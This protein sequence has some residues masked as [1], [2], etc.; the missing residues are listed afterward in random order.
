VSGLKNGESDRQLTER[1][2]TSGFRFTSQR[3]QVYDVLRQKLDHPTAEG[4]F[5]RAKRVLPGISHAT[6]YN[7]LDALVQCGL[8][9]LV[10]LDR[11]A[12]R[13]CPNMEEHCHYYCAKCGTVFDVALPADSPTMPRP[14]GFKIDH[15]EIA[16]HGLCADCAAK[17]KK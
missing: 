2:A 12:T 11:G 14:K 9:R 13:Y 3:R 4:V 17:G 15:Y 5:I 1:L 7:C 10:V 8:V 6:V 16:V